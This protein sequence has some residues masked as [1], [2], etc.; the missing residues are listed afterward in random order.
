M[1]AQCLNAVLC[2][3][4][5]YARSILLVTNSDCLIFYFLGSHCRGR[6]LLRWLLRW[7]SWL[8]KDSGKL[9]FL[10]LVI[11]RM[12][13]LSTG[14]AGGLKTSSSMQ[15]RKHVYLGALYVLSKWV[16]WDFKNMGRPKLFSLQVGKFIE[17]FLPYSFHS[18]FLFPFDRI[19]LKTLTPTR[20]ILCKNPGYSTQ[21]PYPQAQTHMP[22]L[23][24][25]VWAKPSYLSAHT[26]FLTSHAATMSCDSDPSVL[27]FACYQCT[28]AVER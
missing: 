14:E 9:P 8:Y 24:R 22:R 5:L 7:R 11:P 2:C 20:L 17:P 19:F 6:K 25:E 12:L 27:R 13:T 15:L 3:T 1:N 28:T 18:R 26:A 23:P 21:P 4:T 10:A 16:T